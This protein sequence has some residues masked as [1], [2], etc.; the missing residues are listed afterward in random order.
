MI[1]EWWNGWTRDY[2]DRVMVDRCGEGSGEMNVV[3]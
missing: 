1:G 3:I 2:G